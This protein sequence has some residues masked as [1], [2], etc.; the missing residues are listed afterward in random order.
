MLEFICVC[1]NIVLG[2]LK[3]QLRKK[4]IHFFFCSPTLKEEFKTSM[5]VLETLFIDYAEQVS[6]CAYK[7]RELLTLG[8]V[9]I[10]HPS[11]FVSK[12]FLAAYEAKKDEH[13]DKL[14]GVKQVDEIEEQAKMIV[15][16]P[17]FKKAEILYKRKMGYIPMGSLFQIINKLYPEFRSSII[18][19][20]LAQR[21]KLDKELVGE[22]AVSGSFK[23]NKKKSD[24]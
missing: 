8:Y 19:G 12:E 23:Q 22:W 1:I 18:V 24:L 16:T 13:L 11:K 3:E 15:S 6:Y 17:L 21:I 7:T 5:Y 20:E 2:A 14:T 9:R 10:P 4:S